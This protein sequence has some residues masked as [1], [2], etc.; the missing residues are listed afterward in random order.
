MVKN[1][2]ATTKTSAYLLVF[3]AGIIIAL[4]LAG[5]FFLWKLNIPPHKATP[6]TVLNY[7]YHYG[8]DLNVRRWLAICG[9][10]GAVPALG[11][12]VALLM[13]VRRRLHGD[14]RFA[15]RQ[16]VKNAGLLGDRGLILGKLGNRYLMLPGQQGAICSA[17]PRSGKGAG[18]V[19][20]NMMSWDGSVVLLDVRQES[21]RI[22]SGFRSKF[23]A[24]YL[25]NPVA[26]DGKTMQWNPL[27][28]VRDDPVLRIDDLQKIAGMLSPDPADSDSFWTASCRSLFLGLALYVFE[29]PGL[30]KTFG[31]IVRQIMNGSEESAGAHWEKIIAER[32]QSDN[33][34]SSVCVSALS[35]FIN[36][37]ANTQSSI[38]K[39][40][41]AKLELWLSPLVDAAT[42]DN[43]FD[44]R[45]LRKKK[46]S[47]YVGV[48][49]ADLE[50]LQLILN[51]FFQQIID[52]NTSEMPEDNPVLKHQLLLLMDEFTAVG[53]MPIFAKSISFLGGYN[54]RPFIIVQGMS[55][56]RST[57][58][59][60]VAET[61]QTCCA[62][63]IVYAPKEQK[64]ANEV[65]EM[66]G[67]TTVKTKS[68]STK[69]LQTNGSSFTESEQSRR[70]L[71]PQEV[72]EIGAENEIIFLENLRPIFCN[73]ISYWKE[74]VFKRRMLAPVDVKQVRAV[75]HQAPAIATLN[76]HGQRAKLAQERVR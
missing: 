2:T 9:A 51:L 39:T 66:L 41:T 37:S 17:P 57:Y 38:R 64:Y 11:F 19:Q 59:A 69:P 55:Q 24:V 40:F 68:K 67:D 25:F 47:V 65:S 26:E 71:K 58:G 54:V 61:I 13:P 56:L 23:S 15:R 35:D 42:S 7:A 4:Y 74:A 12:V 46:I 44:L 1:H 5:Y 16:E 63:M 72:K 28:Y 36:T 43:S 27:S 70:L 45:D 29:T 31:E 30:P 21:F 22:T 52:L 75:V 73:K 32:A 34:L 6:F 48:R 76:A 53:R 14:A 8:H 62:A 20:P 18:L 49:P 50:R 60:D 10:A 3:T 33:P